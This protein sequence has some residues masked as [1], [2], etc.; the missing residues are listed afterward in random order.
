MRK[1]TEREQYFIPGYGRR[2]SADAENGRCCFLC[3]YSFLHSDYMDQPEKLMCGKVEM[4]NRRVRNFNVCD[5]FE[6]EER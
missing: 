2:S 4:G 6:K 3:R 1:P 5:N